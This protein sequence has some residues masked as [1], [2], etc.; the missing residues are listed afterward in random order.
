M[1]AAALALC[2][3]ALAAAPT[4]A[5]DLPGGPPGSEAVVPK[6]LEL[7]LPDKDWQRLQL[8]WPDHGAIETALLEGDVSEAAIAAA[9]ACGNAG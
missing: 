4:L 6:G 5:C 8:A 1:R 7:V 9:R 2:L 3:S